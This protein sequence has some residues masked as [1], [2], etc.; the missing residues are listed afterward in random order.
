VTRRTAF[1]P[2]R[3]NLI[4]EHTDYNGGLALP[5][6]IE[7]GVTVVAEPLEGE[8]VVAHA[9]DVGE[10]DR[11]PAADPP[12]GAE[13]WRAFVRGVAGELGGVEPTDLTI[14][15]TVPSG[16]GLSSSAALSV[17]LALALG[18]DASDRV[19]LAK[20]CSRVENDWV[21]ANTGL[22]DQL[23]S[24]CGEAGHAL[25]IDFRTLDVT[26]VPLALGG[27]RLVTADSGEQHDLAASGY[28]ARRAEC[29]EAARRLGVATLSEATL[30]AAASLPD[31]LARRARHVITENARVEKT[32]N[33]LAHG[34]LAA[35]G[36]LL[37]GSHASLRD[38][39]EASTDAVEATVTRLKQAGALGAR[40]MGGGFGG[41]VLA[42][43]PPDREPPSDA[44]D[45]RPSAGARAN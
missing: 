1:A 30:D 4:G 29:D 37:D 44:R 21:G 8:D 15:A 32:V 23:A 27:H 35:I 9:L 39:Y 16:A 13:G 31:P 11:F 2:G 38:D 28:N 45:V 36:P 40:M 42:L 14:S 41:H 3:A 26:P 18:A 7:E 12:R 34:E 43:F 22:L 6:A 25:R 17:A 19:A 10:E 5:F 33:A 20:L 24:L